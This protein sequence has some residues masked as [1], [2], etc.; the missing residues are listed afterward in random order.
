MI[1]GHTPNSLP[2]PAPASKGAPDVAAHLSLWSLPW[3]NPRNSPHLSPTLN[4]KSR[5]SLPL[6]LTHLGVNCIPLLIYFT[7]IHW[8]PNVPESFECVFE[9][10]CTEILETFPWCVEAKSGKARVCERSRCHPC[11]WKQFLIMVPSLSQV[12]KVHQEA[13][14]HILIHLSAHF[15]PTKMFMS[16]CRTRIA[17][18]KYTHIFQ[19]SETIFWV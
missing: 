15:C 16:V 19:N 14:K 3:Q 13:Q 18:E 10:D 11:C 9:S 8:V 17:V 4:P 2:L 1:W 5:I 6:P 7:N 12:L